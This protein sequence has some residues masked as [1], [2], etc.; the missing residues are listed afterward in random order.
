MDRKTYTETVLSVLRHVTGRERDAIREEIDGHIEDHMEDLLEL[1]YE[2]E[3][4]EERTLAAMG[5][6]KEVGR[7]LNKQY[8]L[9]WLVIGRT[10]VA[11]VL[12]FALVVAG[13]LWNTLRNTVLPN[14]QARWVP[15]TVQDLTQISDYVDGEYQALLKTAEDLDLRQTADGITVRIYQ[16]GLEDPAA[17]ETTAWFA[18]SFSAVN[19]FEKPSR[20]LWKGIELE[21]QAVTV[22][23]FSQTYYCFFSGTVTWGQE[24]HVVCQRYGET[25]RFTVPL[26]WEEA[27]E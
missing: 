21:G 26:P 17:E 7:E 18:V 16:V 1:G 4:A 2:P 9:R 23:S 25:Y 13:P 27:V 8:P 24:A 10:A 15:T 12:V 11:A 6:P 14:L 20:Y 3:L 22:H 5:D 19:P